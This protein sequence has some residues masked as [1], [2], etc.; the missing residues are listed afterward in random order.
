M[1]DLEPSVDS[2]GRQAC[3]L[4]SGLPLVEELEVESVCVVEIDGCSPY[5]LLC[6]LVTTQEVVESGTLVG[7]TEDC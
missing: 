2:I 4:G 7:D 3:L 5:L 6:F 1:T